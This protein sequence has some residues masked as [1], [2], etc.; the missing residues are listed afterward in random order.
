MARHVFLR[1]GAECSSEWV[2]QSVKL[3]PQLAAMDVAHV[4]RVDGP[5]SGA[6]PQQ[7][8]LA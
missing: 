4:T 1:L 2:A 6:G 8:S 3:H 7:L 5:D